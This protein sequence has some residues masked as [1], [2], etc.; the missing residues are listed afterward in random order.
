MLK[1]KPA[2]SDEVNPAREGRG[3]ELPRHI[4]QAS[5]LAAGLDRRVRPV[6]QETPQGP[7]TERPS[8]GGQKSGRCR[9]DF[10]RVAF[11][12]VELSLLVSLLKQ[13]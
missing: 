2:A 8:K 3:L 10:G 7:S 5:R 6:T 4:R 9:S 13:H 12:R 1:S 11:S